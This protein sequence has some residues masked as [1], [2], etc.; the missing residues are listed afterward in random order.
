MPIEILM[1]AL[2]PTMT[3]GN[4][5]KWHVAEGD[6][7]EAG[8][9]L[10]EIETDKATM[11]VEAVDEGTIGKILIAEGTQDV[12]VNSAISLLLEDGEDASV[13][14]GYAP[15]SGSTPAEEPKKSEEK[16]ESST[17]EP[18]PTPQNSGER[19]FASP[20][21]KRIA[22]DKGVDLNSVNGS[23]PHG[24]IVKRDVEELSSGK[25]STAASPIHQPT[26]SGPEF[27][28]VPLSN[29]RKVIA[30]RLLESKQTVPHFYLTVDCQLDDLMSARKQLNEG[31]ADQGKKITVNDFVI[32]SVAMALRDTPDANAS[33]MGD[34]IRRYKHSD[35]SVAVAI[36]DGLVTPIIKKAELKSIVAVSDEMKILAQKAKDGKL[37]PEEF[38]GGSFS[39]SNLGMFGIKQFNAIINPPQ[40]C[41]MAV[42]AGEK[43]PVIIDGQVTA[44]TVVS[45]TLSS[46]HRVVDGKVG[47]EFLAAF[48]KYME[49]PIL[50]LAQ[51]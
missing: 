48:K 10:A 34:S 7:V 44:K 4:L 42:G 51:G 19:I 41:I 36:E 5:V 37:K 27:E 15:K 13:L 43:R 24:R 21:A 23:G 2:S 32:K 25:T 6:K 14:E 12:K 38:Q 49:N 45:I 40:A 9:L 50:L 28:D 30:K 39:I 18:A 46:D 35:V 8:D 22:T 47:A 1:P 33:W 20:L 16:S 29:M 17:Q 26:S 31:L 3:E 11:E